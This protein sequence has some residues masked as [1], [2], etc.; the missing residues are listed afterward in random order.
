MAKPKPSQAPSAPTVDVFPSGGVGITTAARARL[1]EMNLPNPRSIAAPELWGGGLWT[2]REV[3]DA[4]LGMVLEGESLRDAI[5]KLTKEQGSMPTLGKVSRWVI[6]DESFRGEYR[7]AQS[8]RGELLAELALD[9][10]MLVTPDSAAA[11][12]VKIKALQWQ[13][14]KL[15]KG[16]YGDTKTVELKGYEQ[17][18][19]DDIDR[20]IEA[21]LNNRELRRM[22]P[23]RILDALSDT[24]ESVQSQQ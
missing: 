21:L 5:K 6:E 19:D 22:L 23:A 24:P 9:E 3:K 17:V 10:A 7:A 8:A 13:A 11:S 12:S 15:A 18:S 1:G 16:V 2:T 4:L 20:K 14:S